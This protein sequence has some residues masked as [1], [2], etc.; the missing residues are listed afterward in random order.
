MN[1][2]EVE[3]KHRSNLDCSTWFRVSFKASACVLQW[4]ILSA[5]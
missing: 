4:I 5:T 3:S 1:G 2:V